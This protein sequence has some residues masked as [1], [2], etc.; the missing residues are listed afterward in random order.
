MKINNIFIFIFCGSFISFQNCSKESGV[1]KDNLQHPDSSFLPVIFL[2]GQSNM[3]G[4]SLTS[5]IPLEFTEAMS[6]AYIFHKPTNSSTDDG[7]VEVLKYG[8]NNNWR[9]PNLYF[10]PEEG[11]AHYLTQW[12]H[13]IAIVKYAYG[14]SK[15]VFTGAI[16][17]Y[18]YWQTD[19]AA[20]PDHYSILINN[21]ANQ[22]LEKFKKAGFKPYIA[23]FVWCQGETDAHDLDAATK[24]QAKLVQL[25]DKFKVDLNVVDPQVDN[26][27]IIITRTRSGYP[28]SD[29]I[30][31][32]QVNIADT[33]HNA[34][35]INS[36]DWPLLPDGFHFTATAQATMQGKEIADIL[37]KV[38]P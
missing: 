28:Y 20:S 32:A 31:Q 3:E 16:S 6:N 35:W 1:I 23:A 4:V 26:M 36:D 2:C 18:G 33:Y 10:G 7:D 13:R 12:G 24:Y 38:I 21:W 17:P 11:I 37:S 9:D 15:L 8:I 29:M 34:Y 14:G 27:R 25:L 30:R 5:S 22:S 19:A